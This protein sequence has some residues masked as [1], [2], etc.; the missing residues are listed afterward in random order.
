MSQRRPRNAFVRRYFNKVSISRA[1]AANDA[2]FWPVASLPSQN[3]TGPIVAFLVRTAI[4][5]R[6][7]ATKNG[8]NILSGGSGAAA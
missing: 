1:A 5:L 6:V 3:E 8:T 4:G 7:M 2:G